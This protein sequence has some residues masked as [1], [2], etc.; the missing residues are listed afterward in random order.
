[1]PGEQLPQGFCVGLDSLGAADHQNGVIQ[2]IEGALHFRRKVH[3]TR[4]VK[5]GNGKAIP[6]QH[7]LF[8]KDS[9]TP[10]PL[11]LKGVQ[12]SVPMIHPADTANIARRI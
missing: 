12:K 9:D 11:Q 7:G 1:M 8:G 5:Q 10:L 4:R 3:M 2:Y 6:L